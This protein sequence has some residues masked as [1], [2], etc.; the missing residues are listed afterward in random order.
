MRGRQ[1]SMQLALMMAGAVCIVACS[2]GGSSDVASLPAATVGAGATATQSPVDASSSVVVTEAPATTDAATT[3]VVSTTTEVPTTT[4]E[5][6]TTTAVPDG[7]VGLSADGPWKLVDS[8][9]GVD[10]P[11]L[12]YELMPKLW[13]FLPTEQVPDNGNLFVPQPQDIPIIEAY[14]RAKLVYFRAINQTPIDLDDPG[15][16]EFFGDAGAGYREVLA[17]RKAAGEHADMDIGVVLRPHVVGEQRSDSFGIVFDCALDGGVFLMPDGTLAPG[18]TRG[19]EL[20]GT[21][22]PVRST[23]DGWLV[24]RIADQDDACV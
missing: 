24:D 9:P 6:T 16:T 4:V 2:G 1:G 21:A 19:V 3:T 12:V 13:A 10:T 18:S 22:A 7:F 17:P 8:A 15:W 5:A 11:G 20:S 14:L 23:G